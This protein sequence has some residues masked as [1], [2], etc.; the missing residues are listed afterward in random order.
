MCWRTTPV[1][2]IVP[3]MKMRAWISAVAVIAALLAGCGGDND[4]P[5]QEADAGA[6]TSAEQEDGNSEAA[7]PVEGL[8]DT[9]HA[10]DPNLCG[11]TG[12]ETV[13]TIED[14]V[15]GIVAST[16]TILMWEPEPYI[17]AHSAENGPGQRFD[18]FASVG[19]LDAGW[20]VVMDDQRTD[21]V[22]VRD[23]VG[24]ELYTWQSVDAPE[25]VISAF[26]G[27][28]RENDS[29]DRCPDE[30]PDGDG[31]LTYVREDD[32]SLSLDVGTCKFYL[33]A[34]N[35]TDEEIERVKQEAIAEAEAEGFGLLWGAYSM[36]D[37]QLAQDYPEYLPKVKTGVPS[38]P[39]YLLVPEGSARAMQAE[40]KS[41]MNE[42]EL[43]VP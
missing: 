39:G 10:A 16:C 21:P 43:L 34:L 41:I 32:R 1:S 11:T 35:A 2:I 24:G 3:S 19:D 15:L 40:L 12:D 13:T 31:E 7:T 22:A 36:L 18:S 5:Q 25:E 30:D 37:L 27:T 29:A 20:M 42:P 4:E 38:F 28:V 17:D 6:G 8:R 14:D 26:Y 23:Q 33:F 9:L